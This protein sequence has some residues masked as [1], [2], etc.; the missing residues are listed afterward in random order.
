MS[1]AT[2]LEALLAK[3]QDN[4]LLRYS[5][6][7]EYLNGGDAAAAAAHLQ[8]A[9]AHDPDF[10]AAWKLLGKAH[11]ALGQNAE[12]RVAFESG[13]GAATRK[14]DKQA[15]KEMRVFLKRL[16]STTAAS[17]PPTSA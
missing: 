6:G 7:N 4:A 2:A 8:R 17:P 15:E 14:G 1:R 16:N 3:G 5:L 13:I 11:A 10:S 9:V 12:A